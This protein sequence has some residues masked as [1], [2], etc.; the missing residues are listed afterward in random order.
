MNAGDGLYGGQFVGAMYAEAFFE[1]DMEKIVRAG[2]GAIPKESQYHECISRRPRLAQGEA[3][4]TGRRTWNKIEEKYQK[5]LDYRRFSC[6]KDEK[7]P[8]KFNIDAKLNGAYIVMG[9]L[10]G[11]RRPRQDD[12]HLDPL[13]TGFRLQPGER[14]RRSCSRRS[15]IPSCLARYT[16]GLD[17]RPRVQL[18]PVHVPR[19]D[20]RLRQPR[21]PGRPARRAAA[22]TRAPTARRL[23]HPRAGSQAG[24]VWTR[25]GIPGRSADSR[26]TAE[27]MKQISV[28]TP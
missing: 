1:N 8:Y 28:P 13:R 25:A 6:S 9:L 17:T 21:R 26:F 10:Y 23:R 14:G 27:E 7:V 18:D 24:A 16:K 19:A 20:R 15:A 3:R 12:R 11:E 5:N 4:R 2:P 22:S